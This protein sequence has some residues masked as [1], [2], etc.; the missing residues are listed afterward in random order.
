MDWYVIYTHP[1][2]EFFSEK[3]LNRLNFFTYVPKFKKKINHARKIT[4]KIKPLFP[5]YIFVKLIGPK[6]VVDAAKADFKKM[7]ES[8]LKAEKKK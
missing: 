5:R 1:C 8:G 3:N 2:K 6:A 4:I 7:I